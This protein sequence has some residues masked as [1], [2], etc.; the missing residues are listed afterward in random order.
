MLATL[1]AAVPAT[2]FF[3]ALRRECLFDMN[4]IVEKENYEKLLVLR[5]SKYFYAMG[6]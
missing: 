5:L 6:I 3:I 1:I 2:I 4:S